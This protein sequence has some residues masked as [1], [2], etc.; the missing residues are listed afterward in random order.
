MSL[1]PEGKNALLPNT[2]VVQKEPKKSRLSLVVRK[3]P[4]NNSRNSILSAAASVASIPPMERRWSVVGA[5]WN[6]KKNQQNAV[7]LPKHLSPVVSLSRLDTSDGEILECFSFGN[8]DNNLIKSC[9]TVND[10]DFITIPKIEYQA[11]VSALDTRMSQEFTKAQS[12]LLDSQAAALY[13]DDVTDC[14]VD[15]PRSVH[16]KYVKALEET[17]LIGSNASTDQLAKRLSREL[18]IRRSAE[19]KIIRSPSARKIGT[20]RRRSRENVRLSRNQSWHLSSTSTVTVANVNHVP[21]NIE[22]LDLSFYPKSNLKRGRP[23][24]IQTGLRFPSPVKKL[25]EDEA[26]PSDPTENWTSA[27]SYFGNPDNDQHDMSVDENVNLSNVQPQTPEVQKIEN[28]P[29]RSSLRSSTK[30]STPRFVTNLEIGEI[31]TPMLPPRLPPRR[32]PG[33]TPLTTL[34]APN[35]A[36][37]APIPRKTMLTPLLDQQTGRAS[38]ARLRSQ[39]AGMVMAKAKLFD[40]L[41]ENG[42]PVIAT[43]LL[44]AT[45]SVN[46]RVLVTQQAIPKTQMDRVKDRSP[47]KSTPRKK[48][49]SNKS[50]GGISKRQKMRMARLQRSGDNRMPASDNKKILESLRTNLGSNSGNLRIVLEDCLSPSRSTNL[51]NNFLNNCNNRTPKIKGTLLMN[52]PRRINTP[53]SLSRYNTHNN[54]TPLKAIPSNRQSPRLVA[55]KNNHNRSNSHINL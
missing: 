23:N 31:K 3:Q 46:P 55:Q 15:G 10:D 1:L 26:K 7:G 16:N 51:N 8:S 41:V 4:K 6:R 43:S 36:V 44:P 29:G 28:S 38:I 27:D 18:K 35:S 52:S 22:S 39:N 11:M 9:E 19:H 53:A 24:T 37:V 54:K 47:K 49:N 48:Y 42:Q 34:S 25:P 2:P 5:P 32:T 30:I 17:E 40:G 14:I 45:K 21:P 33:K 50:P 20:M 12:T 13:N